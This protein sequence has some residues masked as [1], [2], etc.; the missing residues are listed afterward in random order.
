MRETHD[1]Q[2]LRAPLPWVPAQQRM[3]LVINGLQK[4]DKSQLGQLLTDS[5]RLTASWPGTAALKWREK[6]R[7]N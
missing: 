2:E 6:R 4:H 1:L 5:L 7:L 3:G